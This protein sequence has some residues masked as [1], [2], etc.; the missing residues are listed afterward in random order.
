MVELAYRSGALAPERLAL[1]DR[2]S[3]PIL[4]FAHAVF[5]EGRNTTVRRGTR[6]HGVP[7]ARL[8]LEDGRLSPP[9]ALETELKVFRDIGEDALR[10][11][12]DPACRTPQGLFAQMGIHYPGFSADETVTLC[13]FCL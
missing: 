1:S 4:E 12:H 2:E 8:R 10:F 11:E 5:L 7:A 13:H 9:V 3:F 6:W